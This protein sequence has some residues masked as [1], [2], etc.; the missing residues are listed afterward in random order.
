ME[1]I[2]IQEG[3]LK[4][5][6]D[7]FRPKIVHPLHPEHTKIW[8]ELREKMIN[9]IWFPQF[10]KWRY[11]PGRIGFMGVFGRFEDWTDLGE[12]VIGVPRIRDLEWHRMYYRLIMDKFS[13][14]ED[15]D[16]FTSDYAVFECTTTS[17]PKN[18]PEER[19][20]NMINKKGNLKKFISPMDNLFGLHNEPKGL[21]LYWNQAKN[22]LELGCLRKHTKVRM[23]DG[24]LKEV[25]DIKI[26]DLLMGPNSYP[27]KVKK[28]FS[29]IDD[30]Y[31][32]NQRGEMPYVVNSEHILRLKKRSLTKKTF[33]EINVKVTD[34]IEKLKKYPGTKNLYECV[35]S[36]AIE[37]NKKEQKLHPYFIG[38]WLGDGFAREKVI[39][40]N[41]EDVEIINWLKDYCDNKDHFEYKIKNVGCGQ[42]G[43]K[44]VYRFRLIDNTMLY[45]GNWWA[46]T[47]SNNKHIP[48]NYL[49]GSIQQ[50]LELL[51]GLIDSDGSY[52]SKSHRYTFVNTNVQLVEQV[53]ELSQSLGFRTVISSK[54]GGV[55][56][57]I[58]WYVRI[59]GEIHKIPC[60]LPRKQASDKTLNRQGSKPRNI[61]VDYVGKEEFY[62]FELEG[63][64]LFLLD[65][66]TVTH[67]SRGGGKSVSQAIGNI[68][69]DLCFNGQKRYF[70]G[71]P[72]NSSAIIEVTSGG[73]GKSTELLQKVEFNMNCFASTDYPELGV[74]GKSKK[75]EEYE[76]SPFWKEMG[77]SI[78]INNKEDPWEERKEVK[79]GGVWT[80]EK[81]GDR[82]YNTAYSP[83][84]RGASQKSAGGR[85]TFIINEEVGLNTELLD[86]WGSNEHMISDSASRKLAAQVGIGTSGDMET[87]IPAKKIFTQPKD[88]SCIEFT[89]PDYDPDGVYGFFLPCYMVDPGF[90]DDDGNTD[91]DAAKEKHLEI[92]EEK[93]KSSDPSVFRNYRMGAPFWID[94]MWV[95]AHGD[96]LPTKEAELREKELIKGE[97]Y[98]KIGTAIKL[99]WDTTSENGVNYELVPNPDP[100]YEWPISVDK[101]DLSGEFMMY[102]SPEKLKINGVVPNDAVFVVHDPYVSEA[103]DEG[104]SLGAAYFIVNPKYISHGLPGN[105]IC[106]AF[107]GKPLEGLDKYNEILEQGMALYGNPPGGLWYEAN[108]GERI[109]QYFIKRRKI[110]LLCRRPQY[111]QGSWMFEKKTT[112]TGYIVSSQSKVTL[113]DQFSDWLKEPTE[114][115][116]NGVTETKMNIE[117]IPCL[118]L[119]K[120][121]KQYNAKMNA[122]AIS[123]CLGIPLALGEQE[124]K[125][126]RMRNHNYTSLVK[127][128]K[129]KNYASRYKT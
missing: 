111:S 104:G 66:Y 46:E 61:T 94:D 10:G 88:F 31:Q 118:F 78:K 127:T 99:Y 97:L 117:R 110:D 12:R 45:K 125:L 62:G 24:S 68:L 8:R 16:V 83:N 25:Q 41:S 107:I 20:L 77:G 51:A 55:K 40:V 48:D 126:S 47:M 38:L 27:R 98:K 75:D 114:L 50:R 39:C 69:F 121:I 103:W 53:K 65:D 101:K 108:R 76:P 43:N 90:K 60:R 100:F 3:T 112:Q 37:Y 9:G 85:R 63:D 2:K 80:K 49:K 57:S 35:K 23:Y 96:I 33:K 67:N 28:L 93:K 22:L 105:C 7:Q 102:I 19:Y 11:V 26:G 74:W 18:I 30:M 89:Y 64:G 59:Y 87:V 122:D 91:I 113:L 54:K 14:F 92:R 4:D 81:T 29:G 70:A 56:N 123:S 17:R 71:D 119:I 120:Q 128:I 82:V 124:V 13:G 109:R 58:I 73:G 44:D 84:Q 79:E 36:C 72:I 6:L 115:T 21:P 15:D 1:W 42:L 32:I 34:F 5:I 52:E 106:A 129:R 95:Q 86:S 116:I